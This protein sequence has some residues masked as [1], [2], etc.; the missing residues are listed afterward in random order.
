MNA[1]PFPNSFTFDLSQ[2]L[3][4]AERRK[5]VFFSPF[6]IAAALAMTYTGAQGDTRQA[7]AQTLKLPSPHRDE[8]CERFAG[9]VDSLESRSG[10]VQL[11]NANSLWARHGAAFR[12][13]FVERA[14]QYFD[15]EAASLD[16]DA[17][18]TLGIINGWVA[19]KTAGKIRDLIKPQDLQ[20]AFLILINAIYFKG[21]WAHQFDTNRTRPAVF[22]RVD[23]GESTCQMMSRNLEIPYW[24][25]PG[26]QAASLPYSGGGF[27][28]DIFLPAKNTSLE[29]FLGELTPDTWAKWMKRLQLEDISLGLPRF[30]VEYELSL[31]KTLTDMGM[32][33]A[34]TPEADFSEMVNETAFIGEVRHKA[35]LEVNEEGSEA[36]AA[37]AV[38]MLRAAAPAKPVMVVDRPFF[39]AIRHAPSGVILFMGAVYEV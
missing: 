31:V 18:E 5:T 20:M 12:E 11:D 30:K 17:P 21:E 15:A 22:Q 9:L 23:G 36:A 35:V 2:T 32:G 14:R 25:G 1:V 27:V 24:A 33:V 13:H 38:M 19:Q 37:T 16:F 4:Q 10:Q 34:F 28:F 3:F 26:F 8:V 29:T 39:C 6:S 7:M